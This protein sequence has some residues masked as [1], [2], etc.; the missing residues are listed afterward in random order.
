MARALRLIWMIALCTLG[1]AVGASELIRIAIVL[2][3]SD[4]AHAEVS[5]VLRSQLSHA[6]PAATVDEIDLGRLSASNLA[7]TRLIITLGSQAARRTL[8][9][10]PRQRIIHSLIPASTQQNLPAPSP[11]GTAS[12]LVLDQPASR[13]IALLRLA[14]PDWR[15][16]ALLGSTAD[17]PRIQGLETEART[18]RMEVR[19]AQVGNERDLYPALQRVLIEPAILI[20]T[21]DTQIFNSFTVQNV[22]LTAYRNRSPVLGFSAAYVRAGALLG[23][24][25][26]PTQIGL[27]TADIA[28]R[29][30]RGGELPAVQHPSHFEVGI[31][32]NV[33][34]S[35][36]LN[37]DS[38]EA[39]TAAL[40]QEEG[41]RP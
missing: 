40:M 19:Q 34:R 8:Q 31:N 36:G 20:A 21:P 12:S 24:Y 41:R 5:T 32:I 37:L 9:L 27:Q 23:L 38:A 15:R 33:A 14:L 29:A 18:R 4:S 39:L 10:S 28:I 6:L 22:L 3:A 17:D 1:S 30:V 7:D 11:N 13:Q 25:S 2:D 26:T 35:L 16:I